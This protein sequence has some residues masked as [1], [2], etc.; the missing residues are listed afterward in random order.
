MIQTESRK[1]FLWYIEEIESLR[2]ELNFDQLIFYSH[3]VVWSLQR[4][5]HLENMAP[6]NLYGI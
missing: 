6:C 1:I 4:K 3:I 5:N 2:R